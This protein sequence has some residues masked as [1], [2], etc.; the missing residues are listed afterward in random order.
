M[1]KK[2]L[3]FSVA[4]LFTAVASASTEFATFQEAH[5]VGAAAAQA[6]DFAKMQAVYAAWRPKAVTDYQKWVCAFNESKALREMKKY[7]EALKVVD[8]YL[9]PPPPAANKAGM[10]FV[11]GLIFIA[12]NEPA[13]ALPL[14]DEALKISEFKVYDSMYQQCYSNYIFQSFLLKEYEKC[15]AVADSACKNGVTGVFR[16]NALVYKAEALFALKKYDEC[17]KL[18][19]EALPELKNKYLLHIANYCYAQVLLQGD[20]EDDAIKYLQETIKN[21]PNGWRAKAAKK[22]LQELE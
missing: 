1:Y 19:K 22:T 16:E 7:D 2:I 6:K 12:K 18:L 9:N 15:I 13:K 11:K 3:F 10:L 4:V 8:A 14:F 21:S 5:K 17:G 20:N